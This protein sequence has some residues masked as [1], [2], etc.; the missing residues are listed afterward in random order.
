MNLFLPGPAEREIQL[1]E[2]EMEAKKNGTSGRGVKA[3]GGT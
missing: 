1:D 3:I 2:K